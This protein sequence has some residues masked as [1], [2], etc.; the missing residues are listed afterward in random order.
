MMVAPRLLS[1][2]Q[3]LF[4]LS[5]MTRNLMPVNVSRL[6]IF[7]SVIFQ[8]LMHINESDVH[9]EFIHLEIEEIKVSS[10]NCVIGPTI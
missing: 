3:M 9:A 10:M 1:V 5:G 8:L 7:S 2:A 4:A 6:S